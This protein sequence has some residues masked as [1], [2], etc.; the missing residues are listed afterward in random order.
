M[1]ETWGD[2]GFEIGVIGPLV[3]TT[4]FLRCL[5]LAR[6]VDKH[7]SVTEQADMG[8]GVVSELVGQC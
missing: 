4:T 5:G 1:I 3:L 2:V 6:I 7:C 8:N